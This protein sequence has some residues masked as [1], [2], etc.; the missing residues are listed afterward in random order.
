MAYTV[1]LSAMG[2]DWAFKAGSFT[3]AHSLARKLARRNRVE[4]EIWRGL[5][6]VDTVVTRRQDSKVHAWYGEL[7]PVEVVH[8]ANVTTP[9][10]E[11]VSV[12]KPPLAV[13][14]PKLDRDAANAL[15]YEGKRKGIYRNTSDYV[16]A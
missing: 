7:E 9:Y 14:L 3:A 6:R 1:T 13:P 8:A 4:V 11:R 5:T 12:V 15:R 16:H 10:A 2:K